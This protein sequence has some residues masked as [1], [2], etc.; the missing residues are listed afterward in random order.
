MTG[1]SAQRH[2]HLLDACMSLEVPDVVLAA[3]P[4]VSSGSGIRVTERPE[5]LLVGL[6]TNLPR[7][8]SVRGP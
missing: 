3:V 8:P 5:K 1:A 4:P 2:G 7:N 6:T